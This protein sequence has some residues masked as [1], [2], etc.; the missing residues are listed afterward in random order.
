MFEPLEYIIEEV[1]VCTLIVCAII[2]P[3]VVK[4]PLCKTDPVIVCV[5]TNV[6]EPVVAYEPVFDSKQ[7]KRV[8]FE[9][10]TVSMLL[11]LEFT[12]PV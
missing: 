10:V 2:V 6:L 3:V 12:L 7:F 5:P 8:M 4:L 9:P 1:T 11:N